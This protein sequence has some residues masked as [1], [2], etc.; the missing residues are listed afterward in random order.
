M[1]ETYVLTLYIFGQSFISNRAIKSVQQVCDESLKGN[2]QLTIIDI[3]ENPDITI[4]E[5]IIAVPLLVRERPLPKRL[6]FGDLN[7]LERIL[8]GLEIT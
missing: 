5:N 4:T 6:I 8:K 3:S 1:Q 2:C 7:N